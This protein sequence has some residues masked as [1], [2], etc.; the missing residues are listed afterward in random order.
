[1]W[2]GWG[3]TFLERIMEEIEKLLEL[4]RWVLMSST[5][6]LID[7]N[8]NLRMLAQKLGWLIPKFND[9][10]HKEVGIGK[11][12]LEY[13][14]IKSN[15]LKAI[16]EHDKAYKEA[17]DS[18]AARKFPARFGA[19]MSSCFFNYNTQLLRFRTRIG[20]LDDIVDGVLK[21]IM[22]RGITLKALEKKGDRESSKRHL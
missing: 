11:W 7:A 12:L 6:V 17:F 19:L 8:E 14:S 16:A 3:L 2:P 18:A 21:E 15:A 20:V 9:V 1:V 13:E 5:D 10:D 22:D 4:W